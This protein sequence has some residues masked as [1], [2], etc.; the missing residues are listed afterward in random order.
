MEMGNTGGVVRAVKLYRSASY[1][2]GKI[3]KSWLVNVK[4]RLEFELS[5]LH[6]IIW[7]ILSSCD[8]QSRIA[9]QSSTGRMIDD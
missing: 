6:E 1:C 2:Y 4:S 7:R 9:Y 8:M 3:A 5:V